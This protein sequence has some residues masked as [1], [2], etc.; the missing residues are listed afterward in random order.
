VLSERT[1]Q[2]QIADV[3]AKLGVRN[4]VEATTLALNEF[5]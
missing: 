4:R 2:R 5:A 1:V 3:Y